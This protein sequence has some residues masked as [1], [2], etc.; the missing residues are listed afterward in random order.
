MGGGALGHAVGAGPLPLWAPGASAPSG[1]DTLWA[2]V[3]YPWGP[4][5]FSVCHTWATR[6]SHTNVDGGSAPLHPERGPVPKLREPPSRGRD[7]KF[8]P[9][10]SVSLTSPPAPHT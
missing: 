9:N 6:I 7:G 2:Q 10:L 1:L 8:S 4:W 3:L 5:N